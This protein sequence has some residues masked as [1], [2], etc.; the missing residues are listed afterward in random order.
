MIK[1][2]VGQLV[3]QNRKTSIQLGK[4]TLTFTP[5]AEG[6]PAILAYAR[7]GDVPATSESVAVRQG[8]EAVAERVEKVCTA[9]YEK[10]WMVSRFALHNV[11]VV[12]G[13]GDE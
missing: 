1:M 5:A 11:R 13:V 10:G 7:F 6:K 2:A 12:A 3:A 9:Q 4:L 8:A